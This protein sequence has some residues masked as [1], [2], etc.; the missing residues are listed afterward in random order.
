[1]AF[2][3]GWPLVTLGLQW[4]FRVDPWKLMSFGMYAV[5]PRRDP[6]SMLGDLS[7]R[8]V[9]WVELDRETARVRTRES[10]ACEA[11]PTATP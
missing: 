2:V 7:R 11:A 5:P 8:C 4:G 1:V 10:R 3:G 9:R 6:A